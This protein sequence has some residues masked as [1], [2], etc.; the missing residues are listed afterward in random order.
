MGDVVA[1]APQ[2]HADQAIAAARRVEDVSHVEP[3]A[4]IS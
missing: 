3:P 2:S 1:H 4:T